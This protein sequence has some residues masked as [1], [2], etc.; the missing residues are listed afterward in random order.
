MNF[1]PC[2][3]RALPAKT[4][5]LNTELKTASDVAYF[6]EFLNTIGSYHGAIEDLPEATLSDCLSEFLSGVKKR[7]DGTDYQ[8]DSLWALFASVKRYLMSK[9]YKFSTSPP[10]PSVTQTLRCVS[11]KL[12][13]E[14][15]GDLP[16]RSDAITSEEIDMMYERQVAGTHNPSALNTALVL[17]CMFLGF[18]GHSELYRR[19]LGDFKIVTVNDKRSLTIVKER[20]T[21]T[22]NGKTLC[23]L[24]NGTP[25]LAE[26][27]GS[28]ACPVKVW[29]TVLKH[30]PAKFKEE[31]SPLFLR[32]MS[33]NPTIQYDPSSSKQWFFNSRVGIK[34]IGKVLPKAV[35]AASIDVSGR[36]ITNTSARKAVAA[37]LLRN[38][39]PAKAIMFKMGHKNI[40]SL[41]RYDDT[42]ADQEGKVTASLFG[43]TASRVKVS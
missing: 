21:K 14:G 10:L 41:L 3:F 9:D 11:K 43:V 17:I 12:K 1:V 40:A 27:K 8:P 25:K 29:E 28:K 36:K 42:D 6:K 5:S 16:N 35:A 15:L 19:C 32:P 34:E 2:D 24:R 31:I 22:R 13:R 4:L 38:N 7:T 18:R 39:T 20:T 37:A 30:R 26:L 23:D 33:T